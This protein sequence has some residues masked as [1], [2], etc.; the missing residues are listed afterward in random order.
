M[1]GWFLLLYLT[2]A[3]PGNVVMCTVSIIYRVTIPEQYSA[4][5]SAVQ[6]SSFEKKKKAAPHI[7]FGSEN[8]QVTY[9]PPKSIHERLLTLISYCIFLT[10][11]EPPL[12]S[13]NTKKSTAGL[14]ID[15]PELTGTETKIFTIVLPSCI[16]LRL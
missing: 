5:A 12:T 9:R 13:H 14:G 8:W 11:S 16:I 15:D 6:E 7:P 4:S 2:G 10:V 1:P 3:G